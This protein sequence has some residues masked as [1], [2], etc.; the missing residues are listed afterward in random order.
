MT[1]FGIS[2]GDAFRSTFARGFSGH[3]GGAAI[4]QGL[5][6]AASP[7]LT[8]LYS[9]ADFAIFALFTA[10]VSAVSPA[11]T[12]RYEMAMAIPRAASQ[13]RA[14]LSIAVVLSWLCSLG[15]LILLVAFGSRLLAFIGAA[16][17]GYWSVLVPPALAL[18]GTMTALVSYANLQQHFGTIALA[19]IA[20]AATSVVCGIALGLA[21]A[22]AGGL[23][24]AMLA[25]LA[26]S[27]GYL[28]MR[29]VRAFGP[30][31]DAFRVTRMLS[32]ARRF[33][34]YPLYNATS[35]LLNG[36]QLALPVFFLGHDY[37]AEVLGLYALGY[38]VVA[39]P[40]GILS[41]AVAQVNIVE[42]NRRR[43]AGRPLLS[44]TL[45]L[46]AGLAFVGGA[47]LAVLALFAPA[48][49]EFI[50]GS[51]WREAGAYVTILVP[52]L[53]IQFVAS[54]LSTTLG[55]TRHNVLAAAWR[56]F[57]LCIILAGL[58]LWSGQVD[59]YGVMMV[60]SC[61]TALS[62]GVLMILIV[63]CAR[64]AQLRGVP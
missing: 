10:L 35:G 21:G 5:L 40:L 16:D 20:Q 23:I 8:R 3:A 39:A 42:I 12:G 54:A 29:H 56:I 51:P 36:V 64:K 34:D 52:A 28:A 13:V 27:V 50:F 41:G 44:Y 49:F 47:P 60:I 22:A 33:R 37:S 9:P 55:A 30:G 38:R 26:A 48:I 63:H 17:L 4:A 32:L 58:H 53:A 43:H 24:A 6:V 11:V 59:A 15:V 57:A 2:F 62:Y 7:V 61:A 31:R 19:R 18:T 1:L 14:L 45:V 25:G 46:V